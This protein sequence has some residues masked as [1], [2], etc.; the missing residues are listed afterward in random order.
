MS[1]LLFV[2]DVQI[3]W[4]EIVMIELVRDIYPK[5]IPVWKDLRNISAELAH[6]QAWLYGRVDGQTDGRTN[7]H[8]IECLSGQLLKW[9]NMKLMWSC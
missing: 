5:N 4:A 6:G 3:Q 1:K 9:L 7:E 2:I 8:M